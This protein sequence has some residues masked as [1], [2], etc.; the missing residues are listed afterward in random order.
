M[1]DELKDAVAKLVAVKVIEALDG[2][3]RDELLAIGVAKAL[4]GYELKH[5]VEKAVLDRAS[6]I[7][8]KLIDSGKY[9]QQITDAIIVGITGLVEKLPEAVRRAMLLALCGKDN[10]GGYD[11]RFGA[12]LKFLEK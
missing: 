10:T 1:Q 4:D 12:M 3:A 8:G 6:A 7:A 9:D 2:P 11:S 5:A